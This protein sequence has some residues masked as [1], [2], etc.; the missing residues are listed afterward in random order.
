MPPG[1]G[2]LHCKGGTA[3]VGALTAPA[4]GRRV[5]VFPRESEAA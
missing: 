2:V 5:S 4:S 1:A 3:G